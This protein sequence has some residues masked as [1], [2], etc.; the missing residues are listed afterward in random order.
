[1]KKGE[2]PPESV[3]PIVPSNLVDYVMKEDQSLECP[4]QLSGPQFPKK[5][6]IQQR[7]CYPKG[8][9]EYS[10]WKGGSLWT[11]VSQRCRADTRCTDACDAN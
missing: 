2:E 7:Y 10:A 9:S 3:P 4:W 6:V 5:T 1:M 11:I 8:R